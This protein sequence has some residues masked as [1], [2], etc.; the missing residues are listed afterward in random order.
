[1]ENAPQ[2]ADVSPKPI[3]V[4]IAGERAIVGINDVTCDQDGGVR[5]GASEG[6]KAQSSIRSSSVTNRETPLAAVLAEIEN[7]HVN[8]TSSDSFLKVGSTRFPG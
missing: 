1:M 5:A 8:V 6:I 2:D 7:G 4:G 3:E